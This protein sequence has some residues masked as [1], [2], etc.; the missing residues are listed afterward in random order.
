MNISGL[1]NSANWCLFSQR[2]PGRLNAEQAASLIGCQPH[3]IAAVVRAKFVRPLGNPTP[4]AVKYFSSAKLLAACADERW[5]DRV[6]RAISQSRRKSGQEVSC[7][8][9][10]EDVHETAKI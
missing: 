2:L 3:D 4:N 5:L 10:G 7:D 8:V 6:T 9:N 1:T